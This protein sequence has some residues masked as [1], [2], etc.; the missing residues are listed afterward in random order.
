[1]A[2]AGHVI[3]A[4]FALDGPTQCSGLDVVRYDADSLGAQLGDDFW[5]RDTYSETHI[6]PWGGEQQFSWSWFQQGR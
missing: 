2:P 4:T 3:M 5:L 6:T 1:M